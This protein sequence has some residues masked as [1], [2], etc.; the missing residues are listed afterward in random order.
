V[1]GDGERLEAQPGGLLDKGLRVRR[2]VEEAERRV[3][4][5]LGVR[6]G[7]GPAPEVGRGLVGLA[8]AGP[9]RAV[10]AVGRRAEGPGVG[11]LDRP[12]GGTVREPLLEVLPRH[13]RIPPAHDPRVSNTCSID[14]K[15]RLVRHGAAALRLYV[16]QRAA[17]E[18]PWNTIDPS[19]I[20]PASIDHD[21]D[22]TIE[23]YLA[24]AEAPV[25]LVIAVDLKVVASVDRDLDRVGVASGGSIYPFVQNL[26][27]AARAR[28]YAGTL[29][30]FFS[31]EEPEVQRLLGLPSHL[32]LAALIPLGR[33]RRE[34]TRLTRKPV[35]DF[36]RLERYDGPPLGA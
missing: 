27:L 31:S 10:T 6:D 15:A 33:P 11:R 20:D 8:L 30:T 17:G 19:S 1:V 36:A 26:L 24:I 34:L 12:G 5:Q 7:A 18:N 2:A 32:A 28:G 9:R 16:A 23:W 25:L 4:V 21:D 22:D 14:T 3:A 13:G 35:S 29:T